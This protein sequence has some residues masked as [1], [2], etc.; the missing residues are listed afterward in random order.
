M[1]K[2]CRKCGKIWNLCRNYAVLFL[3]QNAS[4]TFPPPRL[5]SSPPNPRRSRKRSDSHLQK[6]PAPKSSHGGAGTVEPDAGDPMAEDSA[7]AVAAGAGDTRPKQLYAS[8]IL[9]RY[10][11]IK[12]NRA[13]EGD[14]FKGEKLTRTPSRQK[15][16]IFRCSLKKALNSTIPKTTHKTTPRWHGEKCCV[17]SQ[18][19]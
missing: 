6:Q 10:H 18:V 2:L 5:T 16:T 1:R 4:E 7:A 19:N 11:V 3:R 8:N 15:S 17:E 12:M 13:E 9:G 14:N